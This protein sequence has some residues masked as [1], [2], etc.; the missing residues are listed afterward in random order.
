MTET[1]CTAS[2]VTYKAGVGANA[3]I[4]ASSALMTSFINEGEGVIVAE[5]RKDWIVG[6]TS[7]NTYVKEL[8]RDCCS[9][10]AAKKVVN[11]D[12][13]G[14]FSRI[15]AETTLDVLHDEF[16]RTLK[17]LKDLDTIQIRAVG[18]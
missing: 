16:L 5:T 1:L 15:T 10:Y 8:L 12:M 2:D 17:T 18:D 14:Y 13:S 4:I 11:Y 9:S 6:Y 7:V 3:T